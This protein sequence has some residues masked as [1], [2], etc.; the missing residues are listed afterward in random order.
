M[1]NTSAKTQTCPNCEKLLQINE[2]FAT[3]CEECN[4]N[5]SQFELAKPRSTFQS[6]HFSF[7][8]KQGK[9]LFASLV[10]SKPE[11]L[12]P[13]FNLRQ[14]AAFFIATFIYL[15]PITFLII[16]IWLI[17]NSLEHIL[18]LPIALIF[19]LLALVTRP[20]IASN[21]L[22]VLAKKDFPILYDFVDSI[23]DSLGTQSPDTIV[24]DQWFNASFGQFGWKKNEV[25]TIGL[26]LWTILSQE[27]R[28]ALVSHE[29]CH[30]INGDVRRTIFVG[31]ALRSVVEL[32]NLIHPDRL[33]DP[34]ESIAGILFLPVNILLLLLSYLI[35]IVFYIFSYLLFFDSQKAE[36]LAD[37]LATKVCGTDA[38]I[39]LLN[40]N[41][42]GF[43][44]FEFI[45]ERYSLKHGKFNLFKILKKDFA[46]IPKKERERIKRIGELEE[47]SLDETHPPT[48][49]R[50][51]FLNNHSE[52]GKKIS[53]SDEKHKLLE[54]ELSNLNERIQTDAID[55]HRYG[56]YYN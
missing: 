38:M 29:L 55:Y 11:D 23:A 34:E 7:S 27:E 47:L 24:F 8:Q 25:I 49:Y 33:F 51:S 36:Y 26:P 9:T 21:P 22:N 46:S 52:T 1:Q 2:G 40:K 42:L 45:L 14:I 35:L 16:G 44:R 56:L 39:S 4:W 20:R 13:S 43:S 10:K 50:I 37:Y 6:L 5:L 3:W 31:G 18:L 53:F 48:T 17:S 19:L 32:Y 41:Q 54:T 12:K 15:M 30:G 28:V